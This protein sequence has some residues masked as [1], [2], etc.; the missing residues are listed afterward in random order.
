MHGAPGGVW[1]ALWAT[2]LHSA[3]YLM[4]TAAVALVV[5]EKLGLGLLRRA[6]L[7]LDLVW[8]AALMATGIATLTIG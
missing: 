5:F 7:N 6:W 1:L 8:T 3:G 4:T 2:V